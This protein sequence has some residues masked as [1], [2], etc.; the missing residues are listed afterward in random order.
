MQPVAKSPAAGADIGAREIP[1]A[2]ALELDERPV[3]RFDTFTA[4]LQ[5]LVAWLKE[6]AITALAMKATSVYWIPL[7]ELREAAGIEVCLV[8]PRH[9]K[10]M[11]GRQTNVADCQW[12]QYLHSFGL[13]R[14]AFRPPA[15]SVRCEPSGDTVTPSCATA[16]SR[17]NTCTR[18]SIK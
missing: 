3:R 10:T 12:L 9:V 15:K 8:N 11:P 6:R 17:F 18:L 7:A 4:D 1:A 2:I 14:G 16:P 5:K 13:L